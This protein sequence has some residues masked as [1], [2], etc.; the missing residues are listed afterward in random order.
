MH[1]V[2]PMLGSVWKERQYQKRMCRLTA[3]GGDAILSVAV[4]EECWPLLRPFA[5]T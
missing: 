4:S 3:S 5:D 1:E 2:C